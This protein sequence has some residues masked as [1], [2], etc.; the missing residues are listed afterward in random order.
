MLPILYCAPAVLP[1]V[2]LPLVP[3][4]FSIRIRDSFRLAV[5]PNLIKGVCASLASGSLARFYNFLW[6]IVSNYLCF[7]ICICI[8]FCYVPSMRYA[9]VTAVPCSKLIAVAETAKVKV[10]KHDPW[11]QPNQGRKQRAGRAR[12]VGQGDPA[13]VI[14]FDRQH[15]F[16]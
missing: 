5:F 12:V 8:C 11:P 6:S 3:K 15:Q 13:D 2:T 14:P 7:C 10:E 1:A 4:V 16:Q 9:S